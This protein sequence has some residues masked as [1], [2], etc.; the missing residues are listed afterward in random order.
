MMDEWMDEWM[1]GWMAFLEFDECELM[2]RHVAV[3]VASFSHDRSRHHVSRGAARSAASSVPKK[4]RNVLAGP[5]GPLCRRRHSGR[6]RSAER[7]LASVAPRDLLHVVV[8]YKRCI[9]QELK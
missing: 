4:D 2:I 7:L 8:E 5:E 3:F 6:L 9:L 1:D